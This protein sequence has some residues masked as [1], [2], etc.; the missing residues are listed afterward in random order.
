MNGA[1]WHL[2]LNHIPIF[3]T[4]FGFLILA[5]GWWIDSQDVL[6]VALALLFVAGVSVVPVYYTG[7]NAEEIVEGLSGV[8]EGPIEHHEESAETTYYLLIALGVVAL[9]TLVQTFR[10]PSLSYWWILA[11]GVFGLISLGSV[12]RTADDG[13]KIRHPEIGMTQSTGGEINNTH[14]EES[15]HEH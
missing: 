9:A 3:G 1:H 15:N 11:V 10:T 2:V 8:S 13:G 4:A 12:V 5:Y 14:S 6:R 7:H